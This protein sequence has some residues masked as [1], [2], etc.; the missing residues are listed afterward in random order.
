MRWMSRHLHEQAS[1]LP[2]IN[3][4]ACVYSHFDQ[5]ECHACVEACP[6]Q[7]WILDDDC[8]GL[9]TEACDGC[10]LC[11]SACPAGALSIRFPYIIRQLG[12]LAIALFACRQSS[13]EAN[14][15]RL[16]CL[17]ALGLRQLLLLYNSGIRY[18]LF[19]GVDCSDCQYQQTNNIHQQLQQVN[20][21]LDERNKPTMTIYQRSTDLWEKIYRTDEIISRGTRLSRRQFLQGDNQ[22][23]RK[24]LLIADPL[25]LE[26]CQT[27]APGEL[28]PETT[29]DKVHWPWVPELDKN[30]CSG[31]DACINL[32]PTDALQLN[33]DEENTPLQYQL[34]PASCNG[35]GI[36]VSVCESKAISIQRYGLSS[37]H[38]ITLDQQ[39][40][41]ACG[42]RFHLPHRTDV[43]SQNNRCRICET[44]NHHKNLFQVLA[45][46]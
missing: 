25:N 27:I 10:G 29:E 14:I 7:A 30:L 42:N 44:S 34:N 19:A 37:L 13:I 15:E 39:V 1:Q 4:D 5:S 12:G 33:R 38:D 20:A 21:L 40:C 23:I 16:P 45:D 36:C 41:S 31:C 3:A 28:L 26:E 8:L 46:E 18:L 11:V 9:D 2:E 22:L 35:C 17:N 6:S 43:Q 32:C 24:N